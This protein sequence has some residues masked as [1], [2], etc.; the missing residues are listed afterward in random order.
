MTTSKTNEQAFEW[1]IER[2]LVGS[3]KEEREAAG[4]TDVDAQQP[5]AQQ[6]YWGLPKDLDKKW[7]VDMRR[8]WSFL[9]TTQKEELEKYTGS[10]I[11]TEVTKANSC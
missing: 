1:L 10:D 3:T 8:L 11:K 9:E 5:D 6:Y 7:A 4:L 2:A